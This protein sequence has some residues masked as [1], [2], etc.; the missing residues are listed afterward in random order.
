MGL[1]TYLFLGVVAGVIHYTTQPKSTTYQDVKTFLLISFF[2]PIHI[3]KLIY[4]IVR[5]R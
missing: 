3:V 4:E 1:R 5:G 2:W